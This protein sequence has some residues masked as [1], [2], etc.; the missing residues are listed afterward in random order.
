MT[1]EAPRISQKCPL[2]L[3]QVRSLV[4]MKH[5]M[6]LCFLLLIGALVYQT[7]GTQ[8][9]GQ[10]FSY[11]TSNGLPLY[12]ELGIVSHCFFWL[13]Y[14]QLVICCFSCELEDW[15]Y[16]SIMGENGL[17]SFDSI[18]TAHSLNTWIPIV[19]RSSSS[20]PATICCHSSFLWYLAVVSQVKQWIRFIQNGQGLSGI[21]EK[22][23][24]LWSNS[25]GFG[26]D[27]NLIFLHFQ[28]TSLYIL[29][30]NKFPK[31]TKKTWQS[32]TTNQWLSSNVFQWP[33]N[34]FRQQVSDINF[35]L[36]KPK[37][38]GSS[39]WGNMGNPVA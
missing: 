15:K 34:G 8:V 27:F 39:R 18:P 9:L 14:F 28:K 5:C 38:V 12:I 19:V 4:S 31:K 20:D 36:Y 13:R 37:P 29:N 35:V 17:A 3:G 11:D 26:A 32:P 22:Q 16:Q 25:L 23:R 6:K 21:F 30:N 10:D 2:P 1:R 33:T 24:N 7:S